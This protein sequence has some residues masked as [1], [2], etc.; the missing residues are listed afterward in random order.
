MKCKA[1]QKPME[2]A[3]LS[4]KNKHSGEYEDLCYVCLIEAGVYI[5]TEE[6]EAIDEFE[7]DCRGWAMPE[8]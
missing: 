2:G 5:K 4:R 7:E 1:C 8:V 3:D 6:E